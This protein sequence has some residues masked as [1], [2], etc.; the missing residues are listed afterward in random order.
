ME[1]AS[2]TL[3]VLQEVKLKPVK[4][5]KKVKPEPVKEESS[6]EESEE[7]EEDEEEMEVTNAFFN[8]MESV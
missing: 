6:E 4:K 3:N 1:E 8:L 7:E 2:F 5:G